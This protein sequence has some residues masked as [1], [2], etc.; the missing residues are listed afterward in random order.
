MAIEDKKE[1]TSEDIKTLVNDI[2]LSIDTVETNAETSDASLNNLI[3]A[4]TKEL[5]DFKNSY[6]NTIYP[7][8][9]IY[10]SVNNTNP[11]TLFGGT[12]TQIKDTFLLSAGAAY[13]A[14]KTGGSATVTLSEAQIPSHTH[15][16]GTTSAAGEHTHT[17]GTMNITGKFPSQGGYASDLNNMNAACEGPFYFDGDEVANSQYVCGY[18]GWIGGSRNISFDASKNWS[19]TSSQSGSHTHTLTL[20]SS[21][22]GQAHDNMPPYLV[23][24]MWKRT[25]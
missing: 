13:T 1:I 8:G 14:G 19:G 22:S 15:S 7:V 23:V 24:Y 11:S 18:H 4:L 9:S 5:T 6:L 16:G 10:V 2:Q 20:S 3:V 25:G 21:G 17:R 12:W